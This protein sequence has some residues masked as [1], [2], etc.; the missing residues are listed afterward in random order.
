MAVS[1][2]TPKRDMHGST[3]Q[4]ALGSGGGL[5]RVKKQCESWE[6]RQAEMGTEC[7]RLKDKL[8]REA[9]MIDAKLVNLTVKLSNGLKMECLTSSLTN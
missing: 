6:K 2:R 3:R 1:Q 4:N 5:V 9:M 8:E 7:C